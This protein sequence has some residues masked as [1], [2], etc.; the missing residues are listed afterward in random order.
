MKKTEIPTCRTAKCCETCMMLR[1]CRQT[2]DGI[3]GATSWVEHKCQAGVDRV[4]PTS[5]CTW[6]VKDFPLSIG[7]HLESPNAI[8]EYRFE[9]LK[10]RLDPATYL[11]KFYLK[12]Q[13]IRL[14]KEMRGKYINEKK[15]TREEFAPTDKATFVKYIE[16][17]G[18]VRRLKAMRI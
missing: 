16:R 1:S 2:N 3:L 5:V 7:M 15:K 9:K 4:S 14:E 12:Y 11:W 17:S 13:T 18:T 8:S 10:F 6:W